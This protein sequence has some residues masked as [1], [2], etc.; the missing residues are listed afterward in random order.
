MEHDRQFRLAHHNAR[1][2][3]CFDR[4]RSTVVVAS[5]LFSMPIYVHVPNDF[6]STFPVSE[7]TS[8]PHFDRQFF[9]LQVCVLFQHLQRFVAGDRG[10]LKN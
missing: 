9:G 7:H 8:L 3:F 6:G 5:S 2:T 10:K 4:R 1:R